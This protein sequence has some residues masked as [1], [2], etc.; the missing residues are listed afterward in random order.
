MQNLK[1]SGTGT[2]SGQEDGGPVIVITSF[3]QGGAEIVTSGSDG[4]GLGGH[5]VVTDFL[6]KNFYN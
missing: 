2:G 4:T 6:N 3:E 1:N 5:A